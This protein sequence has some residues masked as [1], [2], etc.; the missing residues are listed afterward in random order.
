MKK[1]TQLLLILLVSSQFLIANSAEFSCSIST[2]S[3]TTASLCDLSLIVDQDCNAFS[4]NQDNIY[5][6]SGGSGS[7]FVS[8]DINGSFEEGVPFVVNYFDG[9]TANIFIVDAVDPACTTSYSE[10]INCAFSCNTPEPTLIYNT[11]FESATTVCGD[12]ALSLTVTG[13]DSYQWVVDGEL[14]AETGDTFTSTYNTNTS[15]VVTAVEGNGCTS[16]ALEIP[17]TYNEPLST[18]QP[19]YT[20]NDDGTY[21]VSL[22]VSG[23]SA[24]DPDVLVNGVLTGRT[25]VI[26]QN[27]GNSVNLDISSSGSNCSALNIDIFYDECQP[28]L[29]LPNWSTVT[30]TNQSGRFRGQAQIDDIPAEQGDWIAAFDSDGNIAGAEA[31]IIN[32]GIAYI[33][34]PIYADDPVSTNIDEGM[35]AG[36][37]FTLQLFDASENAYYDYTVNGQVFEFTEWSNTNG[38][39][40]TAY[41]DNNDVYNFLTNPLCSQTIDLNAGWNLISLDLTPTST[42]IA[43]VF[44]GLQAGNLEFVTGFE[45]GTIIYNP[46]DPPFLNTLSNVQDGAA[47]W[48]R[49]QNADSFT[50]S[51][52]CLADDYRMPLSNG[53]NL[54]AFIPDDPQPPT[55]YFADLISNGDLQY[56]TGFDNGTT[57][58]NP[59]DPPFLN[60]LQQMEN[61]LGYWLRVTNQ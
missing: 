17:I 54:V 59:N 14:Q 18:T 57:I 5:I 41:S 15:V 49:V 46:N 25:I 20:C 50:V 45:N 12:D 1:L 35:N 43:T 56:V 8:G 37:Y 42:D 23:G 10:P 44:S 32:S 58:F 60:T 31:L 47:Y 9:L 28:P 33:D 52:D 26:T 19:V 13:G 22:F 29:S 40:I 4:G 38:I 6:I 30:P 11:S 48:V 2:T 55:T 61:G 34:L 53:W 16:S 7:Y 51:G 21:T 39:P 3:S 36:E 27:N 24:T